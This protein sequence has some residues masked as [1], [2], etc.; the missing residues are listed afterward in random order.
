MNWNKTKVLQPIPTS[1]CHRDPKHDKK[2][3]KS[4]LLWPSYVGL[5]PISQK[6]MYGQDF[7]LSDQRK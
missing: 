2:T 7:S 4:L 6:R 5:Y 3:S 1:L